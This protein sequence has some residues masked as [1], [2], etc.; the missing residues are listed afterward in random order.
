[1]AMRILLTLC[2]LKR[3]DVVNR[4]LDNVMPFMLGLYKHRLGLYKHRFT[5]QPAAGNRRCPR[6]P[7]SYLSMLVYTYLSVR[8]RVS[9]P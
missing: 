1:M 2:L 4:I 3:E 5:R 7:R 6:L 8:M 9:H